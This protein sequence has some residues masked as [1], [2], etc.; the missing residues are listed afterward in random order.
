VTRDRS[1]AVAQQS[2]G[3][4]ELRFPLFPPLLDGCPDTSTEDVQYPLEIAYEY[5]N[6]DLGMFDQEPLPGLDR[7]ASLLPPLLDGLS[8]GE[9]GTPL[10]S[11][12]KLAS[13]AGFD[14]EVFVKDE[15]QNPTW[16]HK[17]RLNICTV[18]AALKSS[19][20]GIVVASSG[21]HGASAAAYSARAGI[22]CIMLA[23]AESPKAIISF[24]LGYGAAV[25][26]APSEVRWSVVRMIREHFGFQPVSNQTRFHTGHPFGTEGYKTIAWELY[27][28]LGKRVPGTVFAPTG[29]GELLMGVAKGFVELRDLGIVDTVPRVVS[30]EPSARGPLARAIRENR[31]VTTVDPN[32]TDAYAIGTAIG[33]YRGRAALERTG[34]Y[35][36]LV[37]DDEMWDAQVEAGRSGIWQELSS[38][39]SIAGFRQAVLD[40]QSVAGPVVC[41]STSSGFKDRATGTHEVPMIS[42]EW[43]EV[44]QTLDRVYGVSV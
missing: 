40:G 15:S 28:Q 34:G 9:G 32:P 29:Y 22:P 7:W 26:A 5:A 4:A 38:S 44:E 24:A 30:C 19:A 23:S 39:S 2:M 42:G 27:L 41:I 20:P 25:L 16:S 13:W 6:T 3:N 14:G 37:S 18:S 21:N 1:T 10:I 31:P 36:V 43:N 11:T 12:P 35:P 33:G 8:M 17:D